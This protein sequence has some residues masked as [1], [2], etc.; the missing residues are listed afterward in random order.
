MCHPALGTIFDNHVKEMC[1]EFNIATLLDTSEKRNDVEWNERFTVQ[2]AQAVDAH[3]P[4]G[5]TL[6]LESILS[7]VETRQ[8]TNDYTVGIVARYYQRRFY[9]LDVVRE[10][11]D[12]TMLRTLLTIGVIALAGLFAIKVVFGLLGPLVGLLLWLA[13]ALAFAGPKVS[14]ELDCLEKPPLWAR[15]ECISSSL[16]RRKGTGWLD[17]ATRRAEARSP[18]FSTPGPHGFGRRAISSR[19]GFR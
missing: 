7:H 18:S 2:A 1:D 14:T 5:E 9:V 8:V 6:V 15:Q 17:C 10:R 4:V 13:F 16:R 11:M 12:F 3:R 19:R